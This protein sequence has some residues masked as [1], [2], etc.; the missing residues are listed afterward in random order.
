MRGF[1]YSILF[2]AV[3]RVGGERKGKNISIYWLR[4]FIPAL[5]QSNSATR[6]H[7]MFGFCFLH[8][9]WARQDT[10]PAQFY[11]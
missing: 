11:P 8:R 5:Y 10:D 3:A 2:F 1:Y 7:P 4:S 9:S 6:Y